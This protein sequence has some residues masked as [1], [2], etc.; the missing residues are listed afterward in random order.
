[1]ST[2]PSDYSPPDYSP[3][4]TLPPEM[5]QPQPEDGPQLLPASSTEAIGQTGPAQT[6]PGRA[7]RTRPKHF[8]WAA[9]VAATAV[10]ILAGGVIVGAADGR[11][12]TAVAAPAAAV[13]ITQT[14]T[15][16]T[17]FSSIEPTSEP[18][19]EP[20]DEP[21]SAKK[22]DFK[23]GVKTLSK[24]C[25]GSAGCN[26]T[27]R[28]KPSYEGDQE[29][30]TSG[31]IEVSYEITGLEDPVESTFTIDDEGTAHFDKEESGSTESKGDDLGAKVTDVSYLP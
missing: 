19:E 10:G 2:P 7:S 20:S 21:F 1:M 9:L 18:T 16:P 25:F 12:R 14:A 8:G 24:E 23:I 31:E 6:P 29:L 5:P 4:E 27:F 3:P 11:N 22:S 30:P 15:A 13:T 26:V 17:P 28:I